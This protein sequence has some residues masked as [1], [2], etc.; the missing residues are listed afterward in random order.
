MTFKFTRYLYLTICL[1]I[2]IFPAGNAWTYENS[3]I[4][5]EALRIKPSIYSISTN[6]C[7]HLLKVNNI[8]PVTSVTLPN[9][10]KAGKI[11][12]LAVILGARF[13]I[14][15]SNKVKNTDSS[16]QAIAKFRKCHKENTLSIMASAY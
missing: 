12:A 4:S 2:I 6:S 13:A 11:A 1:I 16:A 15:P 10:R 7:K 5:R 3:S 9:Q 8:S 14:E